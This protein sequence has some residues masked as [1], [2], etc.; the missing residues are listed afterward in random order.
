MN[1]LRTQQLSTTVQALPGT[2]IDQCIR[3]AIALCSHEGVNVT[4]LHNERE[5]KIMF[6]DLLAAVQHPF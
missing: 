2:Q 5:Y 4:L 1:L 3:E 6:N